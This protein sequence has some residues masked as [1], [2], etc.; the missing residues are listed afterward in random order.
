MKTKVLQNIH[1]YTKVLEICIITQKTLRNMLIY[2]HLLKLIQSHCASQTVRVRL[3]NSERQTVRVRQCES[4]RQT[5][6]VK[7]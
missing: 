5:E 7:L 3:C 2:T 1:K 6:R 4:Q